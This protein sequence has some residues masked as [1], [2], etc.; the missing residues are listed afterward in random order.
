MKT[1]LR[2]IYPYFYTELVSATGE[3]I[4]APNPAEGY[5]L[6]DTYTY[7]G[8]VAVMYVYSKY[9]Q[10][11]SF[12]EVVTNYTVPKEAGMLVLQGTVKKADGTVAD[13]LTYVKQHT[14]AFDVDGDA[15]IMLVS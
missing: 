12:E 1:I 15:V 4:P 13:A 10:T 2:N 7:T 14:E 3:A 8:D 11:I 9:S 6:L 5:H